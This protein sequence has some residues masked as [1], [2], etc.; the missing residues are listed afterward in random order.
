M[1]I[2]LIG[3][4]LWTMWGLLALFGII[5]LLAYFW[6]PANKLPIINAIPKQY[7][8]ILGVLLIV[9]SAFVAGSW[10]MPTATQGDDG[11]TEDV[12][13]YSTTDLSVYS[14]NELT[15]ATIDGDIDFLE[16]GATDEEYV[17][18]TGDARILR[19]ATTSSG[20]VDMNGWDTTK[21]PTAVAMTDIAGYYQELD[22]K[23]MR[24]EKDNEENSKAIIMRA[25]DLGTVDASNSDTTPSISAGSSE[26]YVIFF[27]NSEDDSEIRHPAVMFDETT[28]C[29]LESVDENGRLVTVDGTKYVV[30]DNT[31]ISEDE[32]VTVTVTISVSSGAGEASFDWTYDDLFQQYGANDFVSSSDIHSVSESSQTVTISV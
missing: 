25:T 14:Y 17:K 21:Y 23:D 18:E 2:P 9:S 31:V 16:P 32:Y 28:N 29:T 15:G 27:G 20:T 26:S 12:D 13:Y 10:A 7:K 24:V 22:L 4:E 6:P 8:A 19:T 5:S 3:V 11:T 1:D 30:L